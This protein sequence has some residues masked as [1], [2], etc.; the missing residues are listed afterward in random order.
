MYFAIYQA[1][2]RDE[3]ELAFTG[4]RGWPF[5]VCRVGSVNHSD[6]QAQ[7]VP[8]TELV[9]ANR[10]LRHR[11][12]CILLADRTSRRV[13]ERSVKPGPYRHCCIHAPGEPLRGWGN[14][15]KFKN[16]RTQLLPGI[17]KNHQCGANGCPAIS[18]FP[19]QSSKQG[20]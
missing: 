8:T 12:L 3:Q 9:V 18:R 10:P 20:D 15:R 2:A 7:D 6:A 14:V 19:T 16:R 11:Q 17:V 5:F 13:L 4:G 1:I